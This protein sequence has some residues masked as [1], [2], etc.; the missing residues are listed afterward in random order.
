[1]KK[2]VAERPCLIDLR[3]GAFDDKVLC[4]LKLNA[5]DVVEWETGECI[6]E[7][8]ASIFQVVFKGYPITE[9]GTLTTLGSVCY[10]SCD[11]G[12]E[13]QQM[14]GDALY[15]ARH[16]WLDYADALERLTLTK[17]DIEC[18]VK[19]QTR[20]L[21]RLNRFTYSVMQTT[22]MREIRSIQCFKPI[23]A[24]DFNHFNEVRAW[25]DKA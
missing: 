10:D 4:T 8:G 20:D 12:L 11:Y 1:M 17:K 19:I 14:I 24:F 5:N 25:E 18:V 21:K 16:P 22:S 7:L 23:T 13:I 3:S 6:P 2:Q 9:D 15:E